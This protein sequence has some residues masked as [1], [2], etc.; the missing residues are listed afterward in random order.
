MSLQSS[1]VTPGKVGMRQ[2]ENQDVASGYG[3]RANGKG[4]PFVE[5]CRVCSLNPCICVF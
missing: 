2:K 1:T 3:G 4:L 5:I